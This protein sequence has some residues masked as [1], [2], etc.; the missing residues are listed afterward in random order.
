MAPGLA[1][2]EEGPAAVLTDAS[3]LEVGVNVFLGHVVG[4]D[5]SVAKFGLS[6]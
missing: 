2:P 5:G 1:A 6:R 3:G 4:G